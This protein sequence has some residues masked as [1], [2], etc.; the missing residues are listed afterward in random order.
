MHG[1]ATLLQVQWIG[2]LKGGKR[3]VKTVS[4]LVCSVAHGKQRSDGNKSLI[5]YVVLQQML[6]SC[7][8]QGHNGLWRRSN[9]QAKE[10]RS[11]NRC[12]NTNMCHWPDWHKLVVDQMRHCHVLNP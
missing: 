5:L 9:P 6:P 1:H 2:N 10:K 12:L 7:Q 3:T 4:R 11:P 8:G